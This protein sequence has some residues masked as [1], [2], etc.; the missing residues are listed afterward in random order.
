MLGLQATAG[1][2]AV[3]A[4]LRGTRGPSVQRLWDTDDETVEPATGE[5]TPAA[6]ETTPAGETAPA[7]DETTGPAAAIRLTAD[8]TEIEANGEDLA[9]LKVE[10]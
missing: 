7:A 8:R 10:G 5:S 2:A 9:I 6:D 1:N 4:L 3:T